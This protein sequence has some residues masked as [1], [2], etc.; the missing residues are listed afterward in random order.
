VPELVEVE[1]Y[2][3]LAERALDREIEQVRSP[4]A[5]FLKGGVSPDGLRA[6]L[7]GRR[8][9]SARRIG[10]LL[11][12]DVGTGGPV[13]GIRFGM[14]GSLLVDGA[15]P[16]GRLLYS[17][18]RYDAAWDR[19]SVRFADGGRLVVHDPRRLGGVTLDPDTTHLGADAASIGVAGLARALAGSSAPLKARLLDQSRVAGVGNLIADEVLWRAGL[20]PLRPASSLTPVELRRLHRHLGRTLADL[21]DRGGSHLG[22]LMD[23]RRPGGICPKDGTALLRATVG[24]RT[25][26]W[27]PTHQVG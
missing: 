4:D 11:L 17:S 12:L 20:S 16:V 27:C 22:D 19:W 5:W 6:V 23:E 2:R 9:R 24:G 10:K 18:T 14:T 15:D 26:W 21:G 1:R 8:F 13:V 25:T 7:V 3:A